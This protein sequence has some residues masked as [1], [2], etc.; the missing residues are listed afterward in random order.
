[1]GQRGLTLIEVLVSIAIL[2]AA[3]GAV[4]VLM[5]TQTRGAAALSD[6][7]AA[8]IAAENAMVAI[9]VGEATGQTPSGTEVIAGREFA[10][11]ASRGTSPLPRIDTVT[12][13]VRLDGGEQVLAG[14]STLTGRQERDE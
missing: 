13:S 9:M 12:V 6:K 5:A 3:V 14:L 2:A 8:R 7:A 11:E 1:M 4:L 10:W